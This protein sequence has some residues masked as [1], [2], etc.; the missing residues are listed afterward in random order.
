MVSEKTN[1]L[2]I[3]DND[4]DFELAKRAF[5]LAKLNNR[6]LRHSTGAAVLKMLEKNAA[7]TL[8]PKE[9]PS[10]IFLDLAMPKLDGED[11]LRAIRADQK[12]QEIPVIILSGRGDQETINQLYKL[13]AN[14]FMVKPMNFDDLI[15]FF[16]LIRDY[17]F[18][19]M[20][21]PSSQP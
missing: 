2:F 5:R 1:I 14:S 18:H 15:A 8:C 17:W 10:L 4:M 7:G 16:Q 6:I 19:V 3:E 20:R 11:I 9:R 21:L 12:M 13:G